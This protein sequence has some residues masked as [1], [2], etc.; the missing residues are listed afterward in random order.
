MNL[1]KNL[2]TI[3]ISLLIS[4]ILLEILFRVIDLGYGNNPLER[5]RVYHH[6]HP[7]NYSFKM[8]DPNNE[9]GGHNIYYDENR[10]RVENRNDETFD[11]LNNKENIIFLGDS[12]TEAVQVSYKD[13]FVSRV[14]DELGVP[15][16]NF[17]VSSYSPLIYKLQSKY[18]LSKFAGKIV[19]MQIYTNDFYY[20]KHF[21]ETS[22]FK[23]DELVAIDGGKNNF[24]ISLL[25][26]SYVAR[27]VRKSQL[28]IRAMLT[29][30]SSFS[31]NH[32]F[33]Y[34]KNVKDE[35]IKSTTK[36]IKDTEE[37]LKNQNKQLF[38]FL[39]PSKHLS[40]QNICCKD[41][42]LYSRFYNE[43][44][45]NNISTIDIASF[46]SSHDNQKTLFF[47]LDQHLTAK[48]HFLVSEAILSLLKSSNL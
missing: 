27:F 44:K 6:V 29:E 25:R 7:H 24:F 2:S 45:K 20:D 32:D 47:E 16:L 42:F 31:I 5:S 22:I 46:F 40:V 11:N 13:T 12:F 17:A 41:D 35:Y 43:L 18:I 38:V 26:K 10:F 39:V 19:I 33:N 8:H 1:I 37:I 28:T 3:I 21:N 4:Y 23:N 30:R 34:E 14:G 15:A 36:L 48:G 9:Y